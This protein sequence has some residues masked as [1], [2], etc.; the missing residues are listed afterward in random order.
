MIPSRWLKILSNVNSPLFSRYLCITLRTLHSHTTY[1]NQREHC[2]QWRSL[3]QSTIHQQNNYAA[4][5]SLK[6]KNALKWG[7]VIP[8]SHQSTWPLHGAA[9]LPIYGY[10][11][12][13]HYVYFLLSLQPWKAKSGSLPN[14]TSS[15]AARQV[16]ISK[17]TR[18]P[19]L[20]DFV[21]LNI[22]I[23]TILVFSNILQ[24]AFLAFFF[25]R[26]LLQKCTGTCLLASYANET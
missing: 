12:H 25:A 1:V 26:M 13:L 6:A 15:Q 20:D 3:H 18:V 7:K 11:P 9:P 21:A 17:A 14:T 19:F 24:F 2:K 16:C 8:S 22:I 4:L 10:K 5:H 23:A